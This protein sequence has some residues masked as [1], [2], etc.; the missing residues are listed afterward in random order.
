MY[1]VEQ[2]EMLLKRAGAD[3]ELIRQGVPILSAR[4]AEPY[5]DIAKAAPTL[6]L[7]SDRGLVACVVS[8]NRGRLDLEALKSAFGFRKLKM[9]D[10]KEVLK[11]TGY[12]VGTIP[13]VGL[14]LDCVFD[15]ALLAYDYVYGGTGDA[16]VTLKIAPRDVKRLNRILGCL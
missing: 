2:L 12:E 11:Q 3:F 5:Y 14:E 8:A 10:R 13:L 15:N 7:R 6:V 4:D 9:A 1:T 16:L